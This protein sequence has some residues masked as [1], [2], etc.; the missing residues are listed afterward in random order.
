[1]DFTPSSNDVEVDLSF[2]NIS[3]F[4]MRSNL[5]ELLDL[6]K[7]KLNIG[8][9]PFRCDCYNYDFVRYLRQDNIRNI[10]IEASNA[11][12]CAG[13]AQLAGQ[14][15]KGLNMFSIV[16]E[17]QHERNTNYTGCAEGCDCYLRSHD[18]ALIIDCSYRNLT[19]LPKFVVAAFTN[20][21][22]LNLMGNAIEQI[23]EY[24]TN[25]MEYRNVTVLNLNGNRLIDVAW[26]PPAVQVRKSEIISADLERIIND[27]F[28]V[29]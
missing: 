8:G 4:M 5:S 22:V 15:L 18:K 21:T 2:N 29:V 17:L 1:M 11:L 3:T 19:K 12:E 16:C 7:T 9:N 23:P 26:L 13:P 28:V 14:P 25:W 6:S 24:A 27:D 10:E 20:Q